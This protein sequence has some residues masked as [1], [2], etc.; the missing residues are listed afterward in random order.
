MPSDCQ[1]MGNV[2]VRLH[3][4]EGHEPGRDA[5]HRVPVSWVLSGSEWNL[6]ERG[7][8]LTGAAVASEANTFGAS[9]SVLVVGQVCVAVVTRGNKEKR[10]RA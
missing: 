8:R 5:F 9:V 3:T 1:L 6:H 7:C 10:P 2:D 4:H